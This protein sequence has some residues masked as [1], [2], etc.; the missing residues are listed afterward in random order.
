MRKWGVFFEG[1][2]SYISDN[3]ARLNEADETFDT[4]SDAKESMVTSLLWRVRDA[5]RAL[6][7]ARRLTEAESTQSGI[8]VK[9]RVHYKKITD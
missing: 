4:F 5:Q 2:D 9:T 3:P 8:V 6:K 7:C 1:N